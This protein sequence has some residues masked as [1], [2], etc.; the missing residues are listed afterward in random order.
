MPCTVLQ[1]QARAY[2]GDVLIGELAATARVSAQTLR[3]YERAGLVPASRRLPNGYRDYDTSTAGRV[4]FVRSAQAD[5]FTLGQ[6][7]DVLHTRDRG[8]A[9]CRQVR[10]LIDAKL[11]DV[12]RQMADLAALHAELT[13]LQQ[14]ADRVTPDTCPPASVCAILS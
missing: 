5:G 13:A 8:T 9:P 12:E 11:V 3:F 4:A 6:I 14:R 7:R 1:G 2:P 10:Q